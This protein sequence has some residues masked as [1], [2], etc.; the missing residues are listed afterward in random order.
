V[1]TGRIAAIGSSVLA[2]VGLGLS[3]LP[4][5]TITVSSRLLLYSFWE[6]VVLGS[7]L[8][9]WDDMCREYKE[10]CA[11][12]GVKIELSAFD[13]ISSGFL[14]A[15]IVP[16]ALALT[17]AIT[18]VLAIR[19]TDF[20]AWAAAAGVSLSA[21]VVLVFTVIRPSAALSGSGTFSDLASMTTSG[22]SD[23]LAMD[24]GSGLYLPAVALAGVFVVA[25]WQAFV[26]YLSRQS[27]GTDTADRPISPQAAPH[28]Q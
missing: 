15:A 3:L 13:M 14:V 28:L 6:R 10:R 18:I 23:D 22:D 1:S 4:V 8:G 26:G 25:A 27:P 16:F 7:D 12:V 2:L 9:D 11:D 21:L 19:V 5:L 24:I 17:A 20:R